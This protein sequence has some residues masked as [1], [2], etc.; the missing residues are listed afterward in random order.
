MY[1]KDAGFPESDFGD[2]ITLDFTKSDEKCPKIIKEA[3]GYLTD[4]QNN[5]P[6]DYDALSTIFN[7]CSKIQSKTDIDNLYGHLMNGYS[8]MAMTDYPYPSSFLQPMPA[9]PVGAACTAFKDIPEKPA[10]LK[11]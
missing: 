10:T 5:R 6:S 2:I 8:Y 11:K 9:N 3:W 4:I 7:T 1:F